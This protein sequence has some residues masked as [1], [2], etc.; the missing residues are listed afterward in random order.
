[1][2]ATAVPHVRTEWLK[3]FPAQCMLLVAMTLYTADVEKQVVSSN[4]SSSLELCKTG[5]N[6]LIKTVIDVGM[7]KDVRMKSMCLITMDAH[8]RDIIG[9]LIKAKV[10]DTNDFLWQSQLKGY[11]DEGEKD[12]RQR[13]ADAA[14]WYGYEY[15][16]NGPRLVVTPLTDRIYVTAT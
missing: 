2:K 5:L 7:P 3:D 1:M 14:F 6:D 4:L 13:I 9:D 15:L 11:W 8:C 10:T 16:G 12:F